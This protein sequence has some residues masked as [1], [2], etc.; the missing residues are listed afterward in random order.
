[1]PGTMYY[2]SMYTLMNCQAVGC[3]AA[4]DAISVKV[5]D[6]DIGNYREI[7]RVSRA[8]DDRWIKESFSFAAIQTKTFVST[9][10]VY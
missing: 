7:Y 1:M 5:K 8:H 4:G 10:T 3:E 2:V 9:C 6:G